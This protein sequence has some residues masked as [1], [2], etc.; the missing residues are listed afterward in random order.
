MGLLNHISVSEPGQ[1]P[2]ESN[3][4]ELYLAVGRSMQ[5]NASNLSLPQLNDTFIGQFT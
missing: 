1:Q 4:L 3:Q 5:F 2:K